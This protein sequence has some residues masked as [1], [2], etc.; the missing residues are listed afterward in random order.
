VRT[1][2]SELRG[3]RSEYLDELEV[4]QKGLSM[5]RRRAGISGERRLGVEEIPAK[6]GRGL[7]RIRSGS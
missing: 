1:S 3:G 2:T 4:K 7:D 6:E 5:M